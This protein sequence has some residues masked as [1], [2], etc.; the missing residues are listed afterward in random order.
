MSLHASFQVK[1]INCK[2]SK[3]LFIKKCLFTFVSFQ[4]KL[5]NCSVLVFSCLKKK[6]IS[7]SQTIDS[8]ILN[9]VLCVHC[10]PRGPLYAKVKNTK[11]LYLYF[12]LQIAVQTSPGKGSSTARSSLDG[13]GEKVTT[14]FFNMQDERIN[15][16]QARLT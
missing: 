6:D 13:T 10:R 4:V 5:F 11:Y 1:L 14:S 8:A 9:V 12:Q 2:I 15:R 16:D 7:N 3:M